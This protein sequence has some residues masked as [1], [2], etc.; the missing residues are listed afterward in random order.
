MSLSQIALSDII[1]SEIASEKNSYDRELYRFHLRNLIN[2]CDECN[3]K[4]GLNLIIKK[5]FNYIQRFEN[6]KKVNIDYKN[7]IY[8]EKCQKIYGSKP[9]CTV[10][11]SILNRLYNESKG[12]FQSKGGCQSSMFK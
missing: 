7:E 5:L 12:D 6:L 9:T 2:E 10:R 8:L 3:D 11:Q 1:Q 4:D